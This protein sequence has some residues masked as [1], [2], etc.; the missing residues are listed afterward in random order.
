MKKTY[1]ISPLWGS[2]SVPFFFYCLC[3]SATLGQPASSIEKDMNSLAAIR[4]KAIVHSL[5]RMQEI[6]S[7]FTHIREYSSSSTGIVFGIAWDGPTPPNL[8]QLL[9]SYSS[10]YEEA[11]KNTPKIRGR[12]N[13]MIKTDSVV[14]EHWGHMRNLQGRA[15]DPRLIPEGVAVSE[16]K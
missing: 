4:K 3:A 6:G 8:T 5:Y 13:Q 9:G 16:I 14:V 15:Y 1:R 10:E 11:L 2:V 7:D 12:R